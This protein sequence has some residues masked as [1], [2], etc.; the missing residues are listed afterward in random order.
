MTALSRVTLAS[1]GLSCRIG[2]THC[3]TYSVKETYIFWVRGSHGHNVRLSRIALHGRT[4]GHRRPGRPKWIDNIAE[5]CHHMN[6]CVWKDERLAYD[7]GLWCTAWAVSFV[8]V[9][10]TLNKKNENENIHAQYMHLSETLAVFMFIWSF[11]F[12]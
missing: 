6:I 2:E 1:A 11:V 7:G 8:A 9:S 10:E 5:D 12:R 3:T 4:G